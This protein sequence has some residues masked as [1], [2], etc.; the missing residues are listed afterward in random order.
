MHRSPARRGSTSC[1]DLTPAV[2]TTQTNE[3][4]VALI[5]I[6]PKDTANTPDSTSGD[7]IASSGETVT[8]GVRSASGALE[9]VTQDTS[10]GAGG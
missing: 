10:G 1:V 2:V 9:Q 5:P 8:A 6:M 7:V 3:L 4:A